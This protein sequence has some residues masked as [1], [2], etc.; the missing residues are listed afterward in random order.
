MKKKH[1]GDIWAASLQTQREAGEIID[2][3]SS[4]NPGG[5]AEGAR[6]AV[7]ALLRNTR[8][9]TAYPDPCSKALLRALGGYLDVKEENI[10]AANGSTHL[11]YLIPG[12]LR[13]ERAVIVEPAFSEYAPALEANDT[14]VIPFLL[15]EENGFNLDAGRL[16][17]TLQERRPE[18]LYIAN[19]SNPIGRLTEKKVL[20]DIADFCRNQGIYLVIDEAFIDFKEEYSMKHEASVQDHIIVLRS[21]TKF[22]ALA[23]LR[24]GY[25]I[26]SKG[27][28]DKFRLAMA[29]WSVNTAAAAAGAASLAD[30]SYIKRTRSRLDREG[31]L[32]YEAL[33]SI[34]GLKVYGSAANFF[35]LRLTERGGKDLRAPRLKELLLDRG[36]LI[37]DLSNIRGLGESFFRIAVKSPAENKLLIKELRAILGNG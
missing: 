15:N 35:T 31:P 1:G 5:L 13:P 32:M 4:I 2:F 33:T 20:L 36:F 30:R 11:I 8:L 22:F 18:V 24:L 34:E 12:V 14:E 28:I 27:L 10:L 37:R 23:A 16:K 17:E 3:S 26:G 9:S 19:P 25:M 29:P 7:T 21:M 6:E